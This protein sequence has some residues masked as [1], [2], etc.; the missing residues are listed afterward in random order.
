MPSHIPFVLFLRKLAQQLF[1]TVILGL[2]FVLVVMLWF[3]FFPYVTVW[4][5]RFYFVLGEN[6]YVKLPSSSTH[7]ATNSWNSAW[8]INDR[9][10]PA[11]AQVLYS[12]HDNNTNVMS[13]EQNNNMLKYKNAFDHAKSYPAW[14]TLSSDIFTGQIIAATIILIFLGIFMLREWIMQN[15]RPDVFDEDD[16][17]DQMADEEPIGMNLDDPQRQEVVEVPPNADNGE[18]A[19]V[20]DSTHTIVENPSPSTYLESELRRPRGVNSASE[21]D[22]EGHS[23]LTR[24]RRLNSFPGEDDISASKKK[25]IINRKDQSGRRSR[26]LKGREIRKVSSES[27][28]FGAR[29]MDSLAIETEGFEFTFSVGSKDMEDGSTSGSSDPPRRPPLPLINLSSAGS[30]EDNQQTFL[31]LTPSDPGT[32]ITLEPRESLASSGLST[33]QSPEQLEAG[34]STPERS[35]YSNNDD[36]IQYGD[37]TLEFMGANSGDDPRDAS[38]DIYD[39]EVTIEDVEDENLIVEE[40]SEESDIEDM[41]PDE[42]NDLRQVDEDVRAQEDVDR[43]QN[44]ELDM[45]PG[46]MEEELDILNGWDGVLEGCYKLLRLPWFSFLLT[47]P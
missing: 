38:S 36:S 41:D 27:D 9:P 29:T 24:R 3:I 4:T 40:E 22:I 7:I 16:L 17:P 20:L 25:I 14:R 39:A 34:P 42:L 2:R 21:K 33:Y 31:F 35:T 6:M 43:E 8:W 37:V 18:I 11:R 47:D 23:R 10:R 32:P 26:N 13:G 19:P 15:V 46:D 44:A 12:L 45:F 1:F 28:I 5:W 30:G